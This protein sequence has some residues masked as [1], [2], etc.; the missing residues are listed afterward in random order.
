M[1]WQLENELVEPG[2]S[3][4]YKIVCIGDFGGLRKFFKLLNLNGRGERI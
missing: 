2:G 3:H 1:E 4:R